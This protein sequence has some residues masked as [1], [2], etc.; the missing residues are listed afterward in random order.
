MKGFIENAKVKFND[1]KL[2][3][4]VMLSDDYKLTE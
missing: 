4:C 3:E 1:D 2:I